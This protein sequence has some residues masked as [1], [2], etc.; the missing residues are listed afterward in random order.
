MP[1]INNPITAA[2][3]SGLDVN[4]ASMDAN[5]ITAAVIAADAIG[6]SE[7]AADAIGAAEI[8]NDAIDLAALAGDIGVYPAVG[9]FSTLDLANRRRVLNAT[10][11]G[12]SAAWKA[13]N[14]AV[15]LPVIIPEEVTIKTLKWRTGSVGGTGNFDIGLYSATAEG[16]PGTR[17]AALGSTAF[18]AANTEVSSDIADQTIGPGLFFIGLSVD[19]TTDTVRVAGTVNVQEELLRRIGLFAEAAALPLPATATPT[20]APTT[21]GMLFMAAASRDT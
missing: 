9:D 16:V 19:N 20:V 4:V 7:L 14:E 8:A 6:A 11:V 12:S 5:V 10:N 15:Y 21:A 2:G 13:A 17:L 3:L 18:P 1:Q